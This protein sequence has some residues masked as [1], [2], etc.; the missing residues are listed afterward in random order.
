[1]SS[2][3]IFTGL[4]RHWF[5]AFIDPLRLLG[6]MNLPRY[7]RHWQSYS[8]LAEPGTLSWQESYPRLT[9]WVSYTP[10]DAHY[11]YQAAWL[12]RK[13]AQ[14]GPALHV[15]VGS[16]VTLISITSAIAPTVFVDYRPLKVS[17][18]GLRSMAGN[19]LTLPFASDGVSSL[20]CLH[21]IEH[22]GLGR[23]GDPLDPGG[24]N[25]AAAELSRILA[26]GGRLFFSTPVGRERVQFN[27]HRIF[28]P[29]T[30]LNLFNPLELTDFSLVDDKGRLHDQL[31]PVDALVSSCEYG[32]GLFEFVKC[33][34]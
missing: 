31:Q 22:I 8:R 19:V 29:E 9:D 20:S 13:L 34:H 16:S 24:S 17:L 18:A 28:A 10:F 2:K 1:M 4:M 26:P 7:F 30:I 5:S 14:T 15:D 27:A 21:V 23:Y 33:G 3:Q 25:K 11:F 12:A 32:C 6:V